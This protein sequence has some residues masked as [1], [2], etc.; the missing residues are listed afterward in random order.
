MWKRWKTTVYPVFWCGNRNLAL[1]WAL[2]LVLSKTPSPSAITLLPYWK[3]TLWP[4]DL[5]QLTGLLPLVLIHNCRWCENRI[6]PT[7]NNGRSLIRALGLFAQLNE[8]ST[9]S[10]KTRCFSFNFFHVFPLFLNFLG[11]TMKSPCQSTFPFPS[12]S[13]SH[14]KPV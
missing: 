1:F 11:I 12:N 5:Q 4:A 8:L 13:S 2:L 14:E 7:L 9:F 6:F 3:L 10:P